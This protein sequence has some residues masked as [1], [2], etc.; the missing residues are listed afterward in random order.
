LAA[1]SD[2]DDDC[3]GPEFDP[4]GEIVDEK[5]EYDPPKIGVICQAL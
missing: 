1:S 5:D 2:S 4:N 3:S